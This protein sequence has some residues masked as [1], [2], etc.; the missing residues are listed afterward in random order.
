MAVLLSWHEAAQRESTSDG[1]FQH[2]RLI[3][4]GHTTIIENIRLIS[5]LVVL[6]YSS[7]LLTISYFTV[8]LFDIMFFLK[9]K[10]RASFKINLVNKFKS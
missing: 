6:I 9:K 3:P 10:S 4:V 2:C 7:L 8:P 5:F 1:V